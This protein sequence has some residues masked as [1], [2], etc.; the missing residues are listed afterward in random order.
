MNP[1]TRAAVKQHIKWALA[2]FDIPEEYHGEIKDDSLFIPGE[3]IGL[4]EFLPLHSVK[5][6]DPGGRKLFDQIVEAAVSWG[7]EKALEEK[8]AEIVGMS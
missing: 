2:N 8:H 1:E 4:I 3:P 7:V 5:G 6:A